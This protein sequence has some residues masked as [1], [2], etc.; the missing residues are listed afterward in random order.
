MHVCVVS[1]QLLTAIEASLQPSL[2]EHQLWQWYPF[3][4]MYAMVPHLPRTHGSQ[5]KWPLH[6]LQNPSE[7]CPYTGRSVRWPRRWLTIGF[8]SWKPERPRAMR[9]KR[10][11]LRPLLGYMCYGRLI[12]YLTNAHGERNSKG[13]NWNCQMKAAGMGVFSG[14]PL[15]YSVAR[16]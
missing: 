2:L 1:Y 3:I 9:M 8:R 12:E 4:P 7:S 6:C 5:A 14:A 10:G 16:P 11:G 15:R 13:H